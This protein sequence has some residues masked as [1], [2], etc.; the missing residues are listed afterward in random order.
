MKI[1]IRLLQLGGIV[2]AALLAVN[3]LVP[4]FHKKE[5]SEDTD[6]IRAEDFLSSTI[7]TERVMSVDD[8]EEAILWRLRMIDAA[9][10]KIVYVTFDLRGDEGGMDVMSALYMAAKRGVK[11][12][13]LADGVYQL[14]FLRSSPVFQALCAHENVDA[15]FYNTPN[16]KNI[17]RANYRMH[18]KYILIDDRMYMLGGRNTNNIFLGDYKKVKNI[19]REV[20][21][22]NTA[23]TPGDSFLQVRNY[24]D[25]VWKEKCVAKKTTHPENPEE[26]YRIM[27]ERYEALCGSWDQATDYTGWLDVTVPAGKITLID[28]G[29]APG[30]KEPKVLNR[31]RALM[32][33]AQDIVIQTPYVI[34]NSI[35]YEILE[36]AN[37]TG[38][39][40]IILNAVEKGSNPWGCT[41]FLNNRE[42]IL[43]TGTTVYECINEQAVHTKAVVIDDRIS[44]VGS[45]NYD[46]RSVYLDTEL[47]LVIDCPELNRHIR[48][49]CED[50]KEK[51]IQVLPDGTETVGPRYEPIKLS[52]KKE[53]FYKVLRVVVRPIRHLL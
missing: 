29:T 34:C 28:N 10:E 50:Y 9:R 18:D 4:A 17:W 37:R 21:V 24:F 32:E 47:M 26:Q 12:Q 48:E 38:N 53:K 41:D 45:F 22:Y 7:G 31:L 52:P 3:I 51:S 39:V 8:N 6:Q 46:M 13:L 1:G 20:L 11:V 15:R 30:R 49:M 33:G 5:S 23:D 36:E 42:K 27:E 16:L 2:F 19:D 40:S 44:L 14:L 25:Q 35:M 43:N